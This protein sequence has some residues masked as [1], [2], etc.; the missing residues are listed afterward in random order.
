MNILDC[1]L[2][3]CNPEYS[4]SY[5]FNKSIIK[6]YL[7]PPIMKTP[8]I[9]VLISLLLSAAITPLQG[10]ATRSK[11]NIKQKQISIYNEN[12]PREFCYIDDDRIIPRDVETIIDNTIVP[13]HI[14]TFNLLLAPWVFNEYR[15]LNRNYFPIPDFKTA[16]PTLWQAAHNRV[17]AQKSKLK[18]DSIPLPTDST[19]SIQPTNLDSIPTYFVSAEEL[20]N[21][22]PQWL[23]SA[24]DAMDLQEDIMLRMMVK[25]PSMIQ[26][27][28][29]ALPIPPKLKEEDEGFKGYMNRSNVI[30]LNVAGAYSRQQKIEK[31]HWLHVFNTSFQTSQ[32]FFTENWYQ[33]S[34]NYISVLGNILWDLQLNPV[35]HPDFLFSSTASYKMGANSVDNDSIRNYVLSQDIFQYNIKV[36]YKAANHW[37]YSFTGQFKTPLLKHY[38]KNTREYNSSFMTP[39]DLNV[40]LG[41]TYA[42]SNAKRTFQ[43]NASIAPFS[44]NLRTVLDTQISPTIYFGID[45]KNRTKHDIGSNADITVNWQIFS[46]LSYKSRLFLFYD[47]YKNFNGDWENTFNFQFNKFLSSQLFIHM[48]YDSA[49]SPNPE[50][51]KWK[52][53]MIKEILS[54]GLAYQFST[55]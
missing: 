21:P 47:Y 16:A 22:I 17:A 10:D 48:R 27:R 41:M 11:T 1:E 19:L 45:Y 54:F 38:I 8:K 33:G 4:F 55:K 52:K 6:L 24:I 30:G 44:Y 51:K 26:Y 34:N 5:D 43:F 42:K 31:I 28:Y 25:T 40:G 13:E 32:A 20:A 15:D 23:S 29:W 9:I 39:G 37:Y 53:F 18:P 2:I 35:W 7:H 12:T 50:V 14:P 36:G 46:T 49:Y 3:L